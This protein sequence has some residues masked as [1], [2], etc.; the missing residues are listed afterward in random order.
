[1]TSSSTDRIIFLDKIRY[2]L[3][4]GV[5]LL[6]AACAYSLIIPWWS[7]RDPGMNRLFDLLIVVLDIF[8]MPGLFFVAG[9]F[10]L[11]SL[12]KRQSSSRFILAKLKRLGL[13]LLLVGLFWVPV[14]SYIG[15]HL[16]N[17]NGMGFLRFWWMQMHT[18]LDYHWVCFVS[19][20]TISLHAN[21]FSLWHLWFLSLL[22]IF[23]AL[24]AVATR[25]FPGL[26]HPRFSGE[27]LASLRIIAAVAVA[28]VLGALG[29]A[30]V[31]RF[32]PDWGWGK[33]GGLILIQ[34]TRVP[35]Y[36]AAYLLGMY[37]FRCEWFDRRFPGSIWLWL[38]A[39]MVLTGA[40]LALTSTIMQEFAPIPWAHALAHG[41]LRALAC[42]AFIGL[43][44]SFGQRFGNRPSPAWRHL[45]AVS[46]DIYLIH[47][48]FIVILQWALL[49]VP[50]PVYLKFIA[51]FLVVLLI[52]WLLGRY[53]IYRRPV[54]A[55]GLLFAGFLLSCLM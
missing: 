55:G 7:V 25:V 50:L 20:E 42:F 11:P 21:D 9:Y 23:F 4:I 49:C 27:R 2:H 46:Y 6:H 5:V 29:F 32:I 8:L 34:P 38:I 45:H 12:A 33:I 35:L 44:L 17:V 54:R 1:M 43:F 13:P 30:V 51:T 41:L 52:C 22:L 53:A 40:L 47:L 16:R 3:V 19:P 14:V 36:I 18:V 31:N 24:T 28:A 37:S 48:P 10:A 39:G 15:F 26:F